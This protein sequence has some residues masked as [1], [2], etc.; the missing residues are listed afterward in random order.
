MRILVFGSSSLTA[1]HLRVVREYLRDLLEELPEGEKIVLT[2][3]DRAPGKAKGA[4][5]AARLAEVAAMDVWPN[6]TRRL[7]RTDD[8]FLYKLDRVFCFHTD[9]DLGKESSAMLERVKAKG[10]ACRVILMSEAG[11]VQADSFRDQ[12]PA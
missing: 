5:G 2:H 4:I 7:C 10:L 9:P 8:V 12:P 6:E 3:T 1:K 11:E